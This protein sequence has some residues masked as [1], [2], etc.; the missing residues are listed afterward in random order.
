MQRAVDKMQCD[1]VVGCES[2]RDRSAAD[3]AP[4]RRPALA[5]GIVMRAG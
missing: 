5:F 1:S 2:R 4:K 3:E